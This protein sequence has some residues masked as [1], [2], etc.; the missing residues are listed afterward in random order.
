MIFLAD[1]I[2]YGVT[3]AALT[4]AGGFCEILSEPVGKV[5][6][7]LSMFTIAL[8][9]IGLLNSA[10][11]VQ[12]GGDLSS[13]GT[14]LVMTVL[15]AVAINAS[16]LPRWYLDGTIALGPGLV[17][18]LGIDIKQVLIDFTEELGWATLDSLPISIAI[19]IAAGFWGI[20]VGFIALTIVSLALIAL[21]WVL[22]AAIWGGVIVAYLVQIA[23]VYVGLALAPIFLGMLL[24]EKTR[25]TGYKYFLGLIGVLFWP[26]GW[27]L[28]LMVVG[29]TLD[30]LH[31]LLYTGPDAWKLQLINIA[32][33]GVIA[34]G[35]ALLLSGFIWAV[36]TKAPKIISEAI[37]SGAQV[38]TGLVSA[39]MSGGI[40]AA[41][42]AAS[43]GGSAAM[44]AASG[45]GSAAAG[46][47]GAAGGGAAG[48][49][50]GAA[51]G[52]KA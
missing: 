43:M 26:L 46:G 20:G 24:F 35:F 28:G 8:A 33:S 9:F 18:S 29:A 45:G 14:Q 17:S 25:E 51:M 39:G 52:S 47:A 37:T 21:A 3:D 16:N 11:K 5:Y 50:G 4:G 42:S 36:L 40:S 2:P 32:L 10:Y 34:A 38:G 22:C 41:G 31:E 19:M 12:M 7:V 13:L 6:G 48:G 44:M 15:V 49:G 27:A 23:V 30:P 1:I